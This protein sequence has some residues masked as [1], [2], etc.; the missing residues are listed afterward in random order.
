MLP[1]YFNFLQRTIRSES[2]EIK[3][4]VS[5]GMESRNWRKT[6]A[7]FL[8][9]A[10]GF[11]GVNYADKQVTYRRSVVCRSGPAGCKIQVRMEGFVGLSFQEN[12]CPVFAKT[13]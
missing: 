12:E 9:M 6:D 1:A 10:D 8:A 2:S 4:P 3:A 11:S 5:D 7:V 13:G